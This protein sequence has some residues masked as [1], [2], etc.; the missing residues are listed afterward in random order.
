MLGKK[1]YR[2]ESLFSPLRRET[3]I[4]KELSSL[5]RMLDFDWFRE[6]A[7]GKF[8]EDNGRP[9]IAPEV[10]AS[11]MVLG[12][13]FNITS[14]RELCEEC[15]DRLSFR[16]FIGI[17]DDQEVP[18]HS[19]LTHWRQRLGREIFHKFLEKSIETAAK[20]GLHPGR[21][22]LFDATLVKAS[23]D[24][25]GT[26]T[27]KLDVVKQ[28]NDYLEALGEWEDPQL[29]GECSKGGSGWRSQEN[30]RKL[31]EEEPLW[32]NTHDL[33][34]KLLSHPNKKTDFYH[35]CHF[36]FDASS[37]LLMNAD[38]EH[39]GDTVKMVEFLNSE[40]NEVDTVVGDKG[41]FSGESQRWL[42]EHEITS[43]ISVP[44]NGNSG[45]RVF[46]LDA[47]AYD[48]E[49]DEYICPAGKRL[50]RYSRHIEGSARYGTRR[51]ACVDCEYREYCFCNGRLGKS[52]DLRV[53]ANRELVEQARKRN[54][55]WRYHRLKI[56]RSIVCEGSFGSMKQYGGLGRARGIGEES[57]AIQALLAGAVYNLK[58]V[59]RF[60][61][62]NNAAA[63][64]HAVV[65]GCCL[66]SR[67]RMSL[68]I[69]LR[70]KL[71]NRLIP[72]LAA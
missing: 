72:Q 31:K 50:H 46:G 16:E 29:P 2:Q 19:S 67:L 51:G 49:N 40:S 17:S 58:K 23:A 59:L 18:V 20:A 6:E 11:M 47:F 45:G 56:R 44:N 36:E 64:S 9:S 30:K 52:R 42:S 7:R 53:S 13:W 69:L 60:I 38:A 70:C 15:E 37:G 39:V 63:Q 61:A 28:T 3:R 1:S 57:M 22:R 8:C 48:V 21:C 66:H 24:K 33:D 25:T 55:C 26:A 12:Y 34:A 68:L 35:K 71:L 32:V 27:L 14:D 10:L 65:N 43:M 54:C 41:Y 62:R 4:G 5:K